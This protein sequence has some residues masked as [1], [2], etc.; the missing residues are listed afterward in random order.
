MVLAMQ[1]R[2]L[3]CKSLAIVL[4]PLDADW[5][6]SYSVNY[7]SDGLVLERRNECFSRS[8]LHSVRSRHLFSVDDKFVL[9]LASAI[10]VRV[11]P[12]SFV[13]ARVALYCGRNC[14][15]RSHL[16]ALRGW[17]IYE[18]ADAVILRIGLSRPLSDEPLQYIWLVFLLRKLLRGRLCKLGR[19]LRRFLVLRSVP[20][21][22]FL[23]WRE[24][25]RIVQL[26]CTRAC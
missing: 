6:P 8:R 25:H 24:C 1:P 19:L 4:R 18:Y 12:D 15:R 22:A 2:H 26:H 14:F 7:V 10:F 23:P 16:F 3:R 13:L 17:H 5:V 21:G 9:L 11:Q 20:A